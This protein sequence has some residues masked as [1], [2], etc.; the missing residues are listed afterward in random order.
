MPGKKFLAYI[1]E[2]EA[3]WGS[4]VDETKE[5]DTKAERDEFVRTYNEKH[6]PNLGKE[7]FQTPNWYMVAKAP[8]E[9]EN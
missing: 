3:G 2:S 4:K 7:G 8:Y 1:V 9:E 6:N 5:F